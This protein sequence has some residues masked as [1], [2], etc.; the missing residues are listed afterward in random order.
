M[1][2]SDHR[3]GRHH[4]RHR[5]EIPRCQ[6]IVYG[7]EPYEL[8]CGE[9]SVAIW[10]FPGE[11]PLCLCEEHDAEMQELYCMAEEEEVAEDEAP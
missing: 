6:Q 3:G 11:P 7:C 9:P 4:D 5:D 1:L 8:K 2:K 10:R